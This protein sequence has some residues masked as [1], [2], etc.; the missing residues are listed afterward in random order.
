MISVIGG[1]DSSGYG[2]NVDNLT[3]KPYTSIVFVIP[4]TALLNK[5]PRRIGAFYLLVTQDAEK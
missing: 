4:N 1:H 3:H 2:A 5:K